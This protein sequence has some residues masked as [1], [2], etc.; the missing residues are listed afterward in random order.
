MAQIQLNTKH[1]AFF[2]VILLML[3]FGSL[4]AQDVLH[5]TTG[6]VITVQAGGTLYVGGGLTLENLERYLYA[7]STL[8]VKMHS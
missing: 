4:S 7:A 2:T 1:S 6:S 3:S 8:L 5:A